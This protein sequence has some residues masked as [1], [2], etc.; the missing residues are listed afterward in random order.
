MTD[1]TYTPIDCNFH[2]I[3]LDR[4]T[5]KSLVVLEYHTP[6]GVLS[7]EILIKDVYTKAGEE[8]LLTE[9]GETIRLDLIVRLDGQERPV[10]STCRNM[11]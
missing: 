8:F 10:N 6:E 11:I 5:R 7:K 9:S 2:D 4:A 3:I 1:K